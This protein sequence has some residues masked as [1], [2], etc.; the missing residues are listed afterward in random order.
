MLD[1]YSSFFENDRK[2]KTGLEGY[3]RV[4]EAETIVIGGIAT[5]YCVFFSAIDCKKLGFNTV[6]VSDA[7]RGVGFPDGSVETAISE[8]KSNG[9]MFVSS[10]DLMTN[11]KV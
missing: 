11:F 9:I 7:V 5:D 8:M 10:N 6:V 3:L 2:T 1:S 4:F